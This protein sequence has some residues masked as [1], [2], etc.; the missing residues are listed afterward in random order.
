MV[1]C[2]QRGVNDLR[3]VQ[4][5]P[6]SPPTPLASLKSIMFYLSGASLPRLSWKRPLN[7][8]NSSS[9]RTCMT[10]LNLVMDNEEPAHTHNT[11]PFYGSVEFVRENPGEPVPEEHSPTQWRASIKWQMPLSP[12]VVRKF[13]KSPPAM[14][15]GHCFEFACWLGI[16][17]IKTVATYY[18]RSPMLNR[19]NRNWTTV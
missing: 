7:E 14:G 16:Q 5:I 1:I 17:P 3:M 18:Q 15:W 9:N 19:T 11:Q 6:L 8:C 10:I 2:L 12:G 4:L 13:E